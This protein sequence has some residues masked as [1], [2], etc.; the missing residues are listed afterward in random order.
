MWHSLDHLKIN[1]AHPSLPSSMHE[2]LYIY[3]YRY[4][5][6]GC[7]HDKH[8]KLEGFPYSHS[9]KLHAG[10]AHVCSR[11]SSCPR[12]S[13]HRLGPRRV[14]PAN[15]GTSSPWCACLGWSWR[16]TMQQQYGARIDYSALQK[17][18]ICGDMKPVYG[19]PGDIMGYNGI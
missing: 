4:Y 12:P 2:Y 19:Y 1:H 8:V 10:A 6:V 9:P 7:K 11:T 14:A 5:I 3:I 17:Q 13:E 18:L 16:Y 15:S